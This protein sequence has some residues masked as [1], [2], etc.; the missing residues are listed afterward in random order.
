MIIET[1][2]F[3]RGKID[4][5]MLTQNGIVME[6]VKTQ[7]KKAITVLNSALKE[8]VINFKQSATGNSVGPDVVLVK[9]WAPRQTSYYSNTEHDINT[10]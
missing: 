9:Y 8:R 2:K 3:Y 6:T 5:R 4:P 7:I 10:Q 1:R